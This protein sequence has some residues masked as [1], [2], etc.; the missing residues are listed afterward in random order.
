M[1]HALGKYSLRFIIERLKVRSSETVVSTSIRASMYYYSNYIIFEVSIMY[2]YQSLLITNFRNFRYFEI[3]VSTDKTLNFNK[4]KKG[5]EIALELILRDSRNLSDERKKKKIQT[6]ILFR[7]IRV[8][9]LLYDFFIPHSRRKQ[10]E[11]DCESI[12][13]HEYKLSIS[14]VRNLAIISEQR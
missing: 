14:L 2:N 1:L 7:E 9:V 13:Y 12:N 8:I 4:N 3:C 6:N 5:C 10:T 11:E